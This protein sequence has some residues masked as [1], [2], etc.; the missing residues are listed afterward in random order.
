MGTSVPMQTPN[1]SPGSCGMARR[2]R[3]L[4]TVR[5]NHMKRGT[6]LLL[7]LVTAAGL[8][9]AAA[10]SI[11]HNG[12]DARA[13]PSALEAALARNVRRLSWPHDARSAKNPLSSSPEVLR[14]SRLPFAD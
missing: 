13:T 9:A 10:A 8:L 14:Q 2:P 5:P 1:S 11:L 6:L 7:V 12:L 3:I 4:L